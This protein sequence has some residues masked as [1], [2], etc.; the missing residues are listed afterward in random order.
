MLVKRN[1]SFRA[2]PVE[3]RSSKSTKNKLKQ[4]EVN[5][6]TNFKI[7]QPNDE[8]LMNNAE[9]VFF[10]ESIKTDRKASLVHVTW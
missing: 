5:L 4:E 7:W 3:R 9:D 2:I 10:L 6:E 1:K 8:K